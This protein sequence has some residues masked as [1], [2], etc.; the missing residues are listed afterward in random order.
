MPVVFISGANRGLGFEFA[1]QYAAD[2]WQV[3]A[4]CRSP[5]TAQNLKDLKGV[6]T[7]ALDVADPLSIAAA[8][9]ALEGKSIDLLINNA[10]IFGSTV[11]DDAQSFEN[12]PSD[13]WVDVLRTNVIAPF[14]VT[15][16]FLPL[17]KK[18]ST[19]AIVSSELGSI[20][21]N[22]GGGMYAY[23]S[24]KAAVNMVGRSLAADLKP[25]GISVVLLHPGWVHTDMGGPA[26][27]VSPADSIAG[28]RRVLAEVTPATSGR[29]ISFKGS[30]LPW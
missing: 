13:M 4:G 18:G 14:E 17:L 3:L 6:E 10:G 26:A 15:R 30:E 29:F 27:P 12:Q 2:G 1:R 25:H 8:V 11:G 20:A 16:A 5:A 28:L 21:Q 22:A 7:V 23:R 9:G 24:S 19:V